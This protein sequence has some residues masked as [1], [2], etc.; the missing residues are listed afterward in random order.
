MIVPVPMVF[1]DDV[2]ETPVAAES[3]SCV[4]FL[5]IREPLAVEFGTSAD[6]LVSS[7]K[8]AELVPNSTKSIRSM[9][10]KKKCN[11]SKIMK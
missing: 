4:R 9:F 3:D 1:V 11:K 6:C 10:F 2:D 8:P 7:M 5:T